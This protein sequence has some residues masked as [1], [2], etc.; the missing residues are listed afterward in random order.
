MGG[1]SGKSLAASQSPYGAKWF[2]TELREVVRSLREFGRN[3]LT[4][5]SGLQPDPEEMSHPGH[6]AGR[7]P[8]TGLS[9][10]QLYPPKNAL[11]DGTARGR[12]VRKMKLGICM[13]R[14]TGV[15]GG[16]CR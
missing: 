11:L 13:G 10:L 5:L 4:G 14:I 6:V 3:P 12:F 15:F 1:P 16:L 7:N 2:A 8:L 9:G